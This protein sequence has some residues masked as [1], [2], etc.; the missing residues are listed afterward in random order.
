LLNR[1]QA[2]D[3]GSGLRYNGMAVHSKIS[4]GQIE[5]NLESFQKLPREGHVNVL[6]T[7]NQL[8]EGHRETLNHVYCF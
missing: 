5:R 3:A 6:S 2:D 1:T 7:V 8:N 4:T